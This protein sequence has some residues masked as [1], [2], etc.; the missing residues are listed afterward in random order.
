[1]AQKSSLTIEV[2]SSYESS[3]VGSLGNNS[4]GTS[5][6]LDFSPSIEEAETKDEDWIDQQT[7]RKKR[8]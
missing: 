7:V 5:P 4:E 2:N 3:P 1:M 8:K 6:E